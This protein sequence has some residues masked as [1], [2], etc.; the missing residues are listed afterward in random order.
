M[1]LN[2]Q[3]IFS[4]SFYATAKKSYIYLS[5]SL[6]L[7][8]IVLIILLLN[9]ANSPKINNQDISY[10]KKGTHP[11]SPENYLTTITPKLPP[12]ILNNDAS[13]PLYSITKRRRKGHRKTT[14]N[15]RRVWTR[16]GQLRRGV[17][18]NTGR[19][20]ANIPTMEFKRGQLPGAAE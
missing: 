17:Q 9:P 10:L 20:C 13:P 14:C 12:A 19:T 11:I 15:H 18:K 2:L 8:H 6:V 16:P 5:F 4:F 1:I 3:Y 7:R